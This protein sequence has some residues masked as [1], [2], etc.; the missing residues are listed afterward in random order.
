MKA[1]IDWPN[2][3]GILA[4]NKICC[5]NVHTPSTRTYIDQTARIS[6]VYK[7]GD[8]VV[9]PIHTPA[10]DGPDYFDGVKINDGANATFRVKINA[11]SSKHKLAEFKFQV[12]IDDKTCTTDSFKT[13][14]KPIRAKKRKRCSSGS[15]Y[16]ASTIR[17]AS[18]YDQQSLSDSLPDSLPDSLS[19]IELGALL[20]DMIPSENMSLAEIRKVLHDINLDFINMSHTL[21]MIVRSLQHLKQE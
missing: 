4:T 7:N 14:S 16:A 15:D 12:S 21:E 8:P 11:L 5:V 9:Q 18:D 13:L 1:T 6:L 20:D 19:D 2:K 17:A 10:L 3:E